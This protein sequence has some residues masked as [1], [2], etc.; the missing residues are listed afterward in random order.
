MNNKKSFYFP[1]DCNARNDERIL[2]VRM[3]HGM[4]GY[5]VYFAIIEKLTESTDYMLVKDYNTLA[6]DLRV[7]ADIIKSIVE[8][9]GLFQFADN[10]KLLYSESLQERMLPL[11]EI[12][13]KRRQAGVASGKARRTR[14]E[15]KRTSVKQS[16][17]EDSKEE[18]SN[19]ESFESFFDEYHRITGLKKTDKSASMKKWNAL[20]KAEREKSVENISNY[21]NSLSDKKYCKKARTYLNDKNFNDEF[22][23]ASTNDIKECRWKCEAMGVSREGTYEQY[24]LDIKRYAP[25]QVEFLGYVE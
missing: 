16:K 18:K 11:E 1:H 19:T 23:L 9:F 22:G 5:G 24:Q 13:E 3:K 25:N 12:R 4:E 14:A 6:F 17:G 15:K 7:G 10:G 2:A 21:F 20:T 8:N